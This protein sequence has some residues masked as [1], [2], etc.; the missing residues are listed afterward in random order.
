MSR[1]PHIPKRHIPNVSPYL[2]SS[3]DVNKLIHQALSHHQKGQLDDAQKI[4]EQILKVNPKHFDALQLKATVFLQKKQ[5]TE[6][7][8]FFESA[9]VINPNNADIYN[10]YGNVLGG[11]NK[12]D[13][14]LT[15]YDKAIQ[16][17]PDHANAYNNR[18]VLLYEIKQLDEALISCDRAI[19][20]KPDYVEAYYNR[21]NVLKDLKR[22][23]EA[24]T[25]YDKAIQLKPDYASAYNNRGIALRNL[26]RFDEALLSYNKAIQLKPD[27]A[28]AYWNKS[29]LKILLGEYLEGWQLYESRINKKDMKNNYPNYPQPLWLG[30]ESLEDKTIMVHSEQG[31]GDSIQFCRYLPMLKALKSKH[32][33]FQVEK[34][35]VSLMSSL[36]EE[37][38]I[39]EKGK[40]LPSFDYYCPLLS[41]PLAFK[42]TLL[43]MPLNTQYLY[44]DAEMS[45][46]WSNK[47]GKKTKPRIGLV[48]SGS[49][50]HENDLNR[51]LLLKQLSPLLQLSFEFH[52]L[53]KEIRESDRKTLDEYQSI[54]QHQDDLKDFSDTAALMIHMDLIISVDTSVAHLAG[55]LGKPVFILLPFMPDYRWMLDRSDTPWYSSATLFRQ[56]IVDDWNSVILNIKESL[57]KQYLQ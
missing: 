26:K 55:A 37:I 47:L 33:I 30:N 21:G 48:W 49:T 57:Q 11:L 32:I 19:Q 27:Y 22:F 52:S 42:T 34:S 29:L 20:L 12:F 31:L 5:L 1:K 36:D 45:K 50:I 28:E 51:S 8:I 46:Y 25:N 38:I 7:L 24:L 15:S 40:P 6:A 14:A 44:A 35:L 16:L 23:D 18:G 2:K 13:E 56:P 3:I 41:L 54:Q 39:I 53:Q 10:N 17:K 43:H 9:L 4:Y